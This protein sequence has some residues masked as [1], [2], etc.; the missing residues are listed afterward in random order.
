MNYIV[1]VICLNRDAENLLGAKHP[2]HQWNSSKLPHE[3]S[4]CTFKFNDSVTAFQF[5]QD[6]STLFDWHEKCR[7]SKCWTENA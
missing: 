1:E 4:Y 6:I 2:I 7:F 3:Y 5:I